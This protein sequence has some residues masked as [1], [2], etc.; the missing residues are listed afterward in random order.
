MMERLKRTLSVLMLLPLVLVAGC[1]SIV[2]VRIVTN[3]ANVAPTPYPT[4]TPY[5][6]H[7]PVTSLGGLQRE[8]LRGQLADLEVKITDIEREIRELEDSLANMISAATTEE[9]QRRL[10]SLEEMLDSYREMY[11]SLSQLLTDTPVPPMA[12]PTYTLHSL[13]YLHPSVNR[14]E[15]HSHCN[16]MVSHLRVDQRR[17]GQVLGGERTWATGRWHEHATSHACGCEWAG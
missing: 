14:A 15:R 7:T 6:T 16:G 12:Y 10:R 11:G 4:Y 8:F 9:T 5:P 3:P 2:D 1:G 13:S 17:R